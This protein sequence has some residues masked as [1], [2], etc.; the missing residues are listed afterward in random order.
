EEVAY[1]L[2]YGELPT[3]SQLQMVHEALLR[4]RPLPEPVVDA[5][6]KIPRETSI[7]DVLRSMVS[8][9][10]HFDP[11][12]GTDTEAL[13]QRAL[14]LTAQIEA[15]LS[16]RFL[17]LNGHESFEA[18]D[19]PSHCANILSHAQGEV[20]DELAGRML[21]FTLVIYALHDF[22]ASNCAVR[23]ITSPL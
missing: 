20:L 12:R 3:R 6:R 9:T 4:Y 13:R 11:T 14:W 17:L 1:L 16:A 19:E 2:L 18:K 8:Y 7:M 5:L 23:V 22:T 10:G 15:L 21:T